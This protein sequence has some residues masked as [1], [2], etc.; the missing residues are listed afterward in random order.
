MESPE[1]SEASLPEIQPTELP[2]KLLNGRE[3][4][5]LKGRG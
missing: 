3:A 1:E 5:Y 4:F 2:T